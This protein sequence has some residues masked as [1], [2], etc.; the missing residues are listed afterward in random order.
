MSAMVWVTNIQRFSLNDG[1]GIRTTVFLQGCNMRCTWCHNPETLSLQPQLMFYPARCIGCGRCLAACPNG[2]QQVREGGHWID[3]QLCAAVACGRCVAECAS[4][5][6]VFSAKRMSVEEIMREVRQDKLY[7]A[8][9]GGGVTISGGEC[10]L[11]AQAVAEL[12][13][14]CR[15]EGIPVAVETN[16]HFPWESIRETLSLMDLVMFDVKLADDQA[17]MRHTGVSNARILEN[18]SHL[19]ELGVPLLARTPLIPGVTDSRENIA[20]I[21]VLLSG[22]KHLTAYELLNF[23]PL[24]ASKYDALSAPNEFASAR[25]LDKPALDALAACAKLSNGACVRVR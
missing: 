22:L 13:Q 9:S 18:V 5:A 8:H 12:A 14:A 20:Q 11:H 24:G 7:Y 3:R 17:H 23:N 10:M 2:A 25:P 15:R 4:D 19:D 16:L 6:L 1:P 21:S